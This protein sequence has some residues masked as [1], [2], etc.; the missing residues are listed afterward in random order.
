MVVATSNLSSVGYRPSV[1][2][3]SASQENVART[4]DMHMPTCGTGYADAASRTE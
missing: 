4:M 3:A 1:P 2:A